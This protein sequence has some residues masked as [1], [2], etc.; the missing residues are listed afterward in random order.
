MA[1]EQLEGVALKWVEREVWVIFWRHWIPWT[2][3]GEGQSG[4]S[5]G[6][7]SAALVPK[8]S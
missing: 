6:P 8:L 3:A 2:E 1:S 7:C 4:C 5:G